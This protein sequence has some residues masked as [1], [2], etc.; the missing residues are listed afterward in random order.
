MFHGRVF[1]KTLLP[2][3]ERAG[4]R[5]PEIVSEERGMLEEEL[6]RHGAI[7]LRGFDVRS[8]EDFSQV[9]A[10]FGWDEF[11]YAGAANRIKLAE[12]VLTVNAEPLHLFLNFHHE[13][14]LIKEY[15]NKILFCCLEA[16]ATGGE[17]SIIPSDYLVEKME[18]KA[19]KALKKMEEDG[20]T[21]VMTTKAWH[22]MFNTA[23]EIEAAKRDTD[24]LQ[25]VA[26]YSFGGDTRYLV[27]IDPEGILLWF[28]C[29]EERRRENLGH[30][31]KNDLS[32]FGV[33]FSMATIINSVVDYLHSDIW[34]D[35]EMQ[36]AQN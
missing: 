19:A 2:A 6:Q 31:S 8:P 30:I 16:P 23:D 5:L 4:H 15:P 27:E 3:P 7:L 11:V 13:M 20:I 29:P 10:A 14:A 36:K 35:H 26:A 24:S 21:A 32:L 28:S 22:R 12:R 18:E 25:S 17:T 9:V 33:G 34:V 1:P